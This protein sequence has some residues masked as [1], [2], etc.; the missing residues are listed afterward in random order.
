MRKGIGHMGL[1]LYLSAFSYI[2]EGQNFIGVHKNEIAGLLNQ[3]NPQFKLDRNVV[4]H[5]YNYLKY[6][7]KVSEQTILF[8]LSDED[9]C[10]YVRWMADYSN[11]SDM[12]GMLNQKYRKN[13]SNS[14]SYSDKAGDY[15][16]TLVEEEWYF[17]VTFRKN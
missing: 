7:D 17:T 2:V 14:W 10:T 4:N 15:S 9:E 13:G 8:F 3:V 12:T 5:T 11:L 1:F 6:V 16:V